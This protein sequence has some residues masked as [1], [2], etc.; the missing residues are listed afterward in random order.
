MNR[1]TIRAWES[2]YDFLKP[3]RNGIGYRTYSDREVEIVKRVKERVDKGQM[4][5]LAIKV[6]MKEMGCVGNEQT[7]NG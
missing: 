4:A 7:A 5:S 6:V 3:E 1:N 2:R